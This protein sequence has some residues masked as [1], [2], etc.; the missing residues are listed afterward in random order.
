M[1]VTGLSFLVEMMLVSA[2]GSGQR[3]NGRPRSNG[4]ADYDQ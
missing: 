3:P 4:R 1:V 2:P